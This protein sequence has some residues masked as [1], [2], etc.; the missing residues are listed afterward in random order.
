MTSQK[1]KVLYQYKTT[2]LPGDRRPGDLTIPLKR[3]VPET[4]RRNGKK[5]K[6]RFQVL[7]DGNTWSDTSL[8]VL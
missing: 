5:V 7:M 4:A 3:I 2:L 6:I 1:G 8:I